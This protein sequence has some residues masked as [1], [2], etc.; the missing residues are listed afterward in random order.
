MTVAVPSLSESAAP[1][2][3]NRRAAIERIGRNLGVGDRSVDGQ[4]RMDLPH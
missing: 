1:S 3:H 4:Y 2:R